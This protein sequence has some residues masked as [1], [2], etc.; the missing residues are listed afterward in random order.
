MGCSGQGSVN[1]HLCKVTQSQCWVSPAMGDVS[2]FKE[3]AY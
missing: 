3:R 2:P 1:A